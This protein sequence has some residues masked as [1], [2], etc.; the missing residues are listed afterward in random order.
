MYTNDNYVSPY[1]LRPRRSYGEVMRNTS[2]KTA[3]ATSGEGGIASN[4]A[5]HEGVA[6]GIPKRAPRRAGEAR[7]QPCRQLP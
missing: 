5:D 6:S 1:L 4:R 2:M 7:P 3:R